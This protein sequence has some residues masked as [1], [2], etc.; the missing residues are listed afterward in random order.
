MSLSSP[1]NTVLV[2][3][4][5]TQCAE[6]L[7]EGVRR[8]GYQVTVQPQGENDPADV[9]LCDIGTPEGFAALTDARIAWP[10]APIIAVARQAPLETVLAAL[11][12][13]AV[14]CVLKPETE[15]LQLQNSLQRQCEWIRLERE[16]AAY[17][18]A[19]EQA[20]AQLRVNLH[21]LEEDQAAGRELQRKLLP[22]SPLSLGDVLASFHIQPSLYLS[23]DCVDYFKLPDGRTLFY[24]ADISGHGASSAVVA[25]LL[26]FMVRRFVSRAVREDRLNELCVVQLL[27]QLNHELESAELDKH[28]TLV[29]GLL[30][31]PNN[32]LHYGVAGHLPAP[33]L[34][35][36][37]RAHY[38]QGEGMPIG[39][40]AQAQYSEHTVTLP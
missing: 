15:W 33:L 40:F 11:Q 4:T 25:G 23:G 21:R 19:L 36:E 8:L 22:K 6:R 37:G 5:D 3:D 17:R 14:D 13:G 32:K 16:N 18:Q 39:L 2:I 31:I 24:L 12:A 7:A 28:A 26:K 20:N 9:V 29:L 38:L 35:S 1:V 34:Y 30:D 10:D 27:Q